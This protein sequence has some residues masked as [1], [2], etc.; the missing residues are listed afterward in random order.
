MAAIL[1]YSRTFGFRD[2]YINMDD[3]GRGSP[4]KLTPIPQAPRQ[5]V[6]TPQSHVVTTIIPYNDKNNRHKGEDNNCIAPYTD[7]DDA[8]RLYDGEILFARDDDVMTQ[9]YI[10]NNMP[11]VRGFSNMAGI[12]WDE[13]DKLR[14]IGMCTNGG[15]GYGTEP[16]KDNEASVCLVHGLSTTWNTGDEPIIAGQRV[17]ACPIP[18][19]IGRGDQRIKGIE[20]YFYNEGKWLAATYPL[21]D[22]NITGMVTAISEIAIK[23]FSNTPNI[24]KLNYDG[25]KPDD[26]QTAVT[27][28]MMENLGLTPLMPLW[29]YAHLRASLA[30][31]DGWAGKQNDDSTGD[32]AKVPPEVYEYMVMAYNMFIDK[33]NFVARIYNKSLGEEPLQQGQFNP[34]QYA[35]LSY[36]ML[37]VRLRSRIDLAITRVITKANEWLNRMVIGVAVTGARPGQVFDILLGYAHS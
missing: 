32:D 36:R 37:C 5:S 18:Y 29:T 6:I 23:M 22:T 19:T 2:P 31:L 34:D 21:R 33:T 4:F 24:H 16:D 3:Y 27:A 15:A 30:L 26:I 8:Y 10:P 13:L 7:Q 11:S 28:K 35:N 12:R 9:K 20:A 1:D 25:M 17:W 14:P